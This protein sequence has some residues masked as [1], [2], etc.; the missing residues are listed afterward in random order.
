MSN[1]DGGSAFPSHESMGHHG[2]TL[3]DYFAAKAMV[4]MI[5]EPVNTGDVSL[6]LHICRAIGKNTDNP[7]SNIAAAAYHVA[8]AMLIAKRQKEATDGT[9]Y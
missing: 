5:A 2:M 3:R 6:S 8:D 7:A 9:T 1:F 4:A